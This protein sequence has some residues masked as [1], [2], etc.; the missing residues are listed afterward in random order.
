I[1]TLSMLST[2]FVIASLV[3]TARFAQPIGAACFY[4]MMALSGLFFPLRE[5]PRPLELVALALPTTHATALM[6]G[7]WNGSGWLPLWPHLVALAAIFAA[8]TALSARI[9]RWE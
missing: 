3:P 9:F 8:C 2:G 6:Q 7:I 5:L 1:A 4:P